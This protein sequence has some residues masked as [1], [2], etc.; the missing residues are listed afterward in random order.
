MDINTTERKKKCQRCEVVFSC[1]TE[2]CW[3]N[4]LPQ[5]MPLTENEECLCPICLKLTIDA[6]MKAE[7]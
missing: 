5:I 4:E 3:C 7:K 1:Y 6:K 2:N